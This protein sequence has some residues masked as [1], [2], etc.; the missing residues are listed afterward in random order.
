MS[1]TNN[2]FKI[3]RLS[4]SYRKILKYR[5]SSQIW[6]VCQRREKK[7]SSQIQRYQPNIALASQILATLLELF[8]QA[9][10]GQM[11]GGGTMYRRPRTLA[12]LPIL[13]LPSASSTKFI[14]YTSRVCILVPRCSFM[15]LQ[16]VLILETK[17]QFQYMGF[18]LKI[19]QPARRLIAV[20]VHSGIAKWEEAFHMPKYFTGSNSM[21]L[22]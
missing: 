4:G 13:Q 21:K 6:S 20:D 12:S 3:K 11:H 8:L 18:I 9:T 1:F 10:A 15:Q 5:Q 19:L 16:S 7:Q 17:Y 14:Q 2:A 22:L